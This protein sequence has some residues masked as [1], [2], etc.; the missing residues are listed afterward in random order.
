MEYIFQTTN[1]YLYVCMYIRRVRKHKQTHESKIIGTYKIEYLEL[2]HRL[3]LKLAAYFCSRLALTTTTYSSISMNTT[4][5]GTTK[6]L[7]RL[8]HRQ[9]IVKITAPRRT[10]VLCCQFK[11]TSMIR[12]FRSA[13]LIRSTHSLNLN[14]GGT[15]THIDQPIYIQINRHTRCVYSP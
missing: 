8:R 6:R 1:R 15:H 9:I 2:S 4:T 5:L 10:L 11:L 3:N 12:I 14:S 7:D 13:L